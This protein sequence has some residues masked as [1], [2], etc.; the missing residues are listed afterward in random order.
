MTDRWTRILAP[1]PGPMTLD[2]TN[3]YVLREPGGSRAVVVDPGPGDPSHLQA[4]AAEAPIALILLTHG[5]ADHAQGARPLSEMT[6]APVRALDPRHR[7]GGEGL[8]EGDRIEVAGLE[9]EVVATPGH[10]PDSLSFLLPAERAVLTGDTVLGRGPSVV[11]HPEGRLGDYLASLRRLSALAEQRVDLVLP[12]HGDPARP[13]SELIKA[14]YEHRM[15]R[16]AAVSAMVASGRTGV[17]AIL[18]GVY[19]EI[20]PALRPAARR[21]VQA[22]LAFLDEK[23]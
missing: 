13:A 9:I 21:S 3:T 20:G 8:A 15:T 16:L 14:L 18:D 5:H 19:A 11:A 7:L 6:G 10:S 22:Q 23:H 17:E 2:G 12:G 1:N 4:V